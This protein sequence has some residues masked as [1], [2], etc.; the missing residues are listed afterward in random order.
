[1]HN[2]GQKV[3]DFWDQW[4]IN[5]T[6]YPLAIALLLG[7][8]GLAILEVIR[9]YVFGVS[10]I[11]QQDIVIYTLLMS[12]FLFFSYTQHVR[13][14][15]EVTLL[16]DFL[17]H[18]GRAANSAVRVMKLVG[19][20]ISAGYVIL[21]LYWGSPLPAQYR[22][23]GIMVRSQL[24]PF[25]PFFLVFVISLVPLAITFLIQFYQELKG[26]DSSTAAGH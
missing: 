11:W 1:M 8:T 15:V 22:E 4:I 9:R 17:S 19:Y 18:R 5:R 3:I 25:W 14:N 24:C 13:A 23:C 12:I 16:L 2:G 20:L 26:A 6:V 21:L 10:F 7:G